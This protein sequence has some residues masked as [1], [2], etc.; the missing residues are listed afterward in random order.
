MARTPLLNISELITDPDFCQDFAIIRKAGNWDNGR[1]ITTET[2]IN[3]YG[4]IDPQATEEM[5]FN[6]DGV[7]L[8][9]LIKVYTHMNLYTTRKA[10]QTVEG[11][12]SDRIVWQDSNYIVLNE[13]NYSDYGYR[14]YTCQLEEASGVSS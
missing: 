12:I 4:I 8:H 9:G 5:Q 10:T 3:S 13:D 14:A 11:Y 7:L 1:F 2:T 6:P